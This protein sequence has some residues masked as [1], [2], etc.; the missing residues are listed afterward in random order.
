MRYSKE[1]IEEP[2]QEFLPRNE[3]YKVKRRK[4]RQRK[5]RKKKK[6]SGF[7]AELFSILLSIGVTL[8]VMFLLYTYVGTLFT[9]SGQSMYPTLHD[10]DKMVMSKLNEID[11]F[12]IVVVDAPD[13]PKAYIKRVIGMPGDRITMF[14]GR[15]YIN[16]LEV[17][18][19]FINDGLPEDEK[20]VF[21]DDFTLFGLTGEGVV[22][23]NQYFVMGDN[24]GVS[25]DSRMLGFISREHI[26]GEA[27]FTFW[28]I[29]RIGR[30]TDYSSLY[31]K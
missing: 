20:T 5:E 11:R 4:R 8:G 14:Q 31:A 6:R 27:V 26:K 29:N 7:L 18:Q 25:K 17:E 30:P 10:G 23:E 16:D 3:V 2:V 12:D 28:P 22:P 9:V 24:R 13:E 15:L 1:P 21:I 19:P